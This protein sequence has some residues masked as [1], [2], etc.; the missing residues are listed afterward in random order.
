[1]SEESNV[2][3]Y[4]LDTITRSVR[5]VAGV[6]P[7]TVTRVSL[8]V[9]LALEDSATDPAGELLGL[10]LNQGAKALA[11][12]L[13]SITSSVRNGVRSRTEQLN[14]TDG[15]LSKVSA[16][17]NALEFVV[18]AAT[19]ARGAWAAA[20]YVPVQVEGQPADDGELPALT[21]DGSITS[22]SVDPVT[23]SEGVL[24]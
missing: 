11:S 2:V 22:Q 20:G 3:E 18:Q 16:F 6:W 15:A 9:A 1:M 21:S 5:F 19:E 7:K 10:K 23:E 14:A 13:G 17:G 24:S 12:T 4:K 8:G